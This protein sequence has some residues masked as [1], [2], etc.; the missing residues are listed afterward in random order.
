MLSSVLL[1]LNIGSG[2]MVLIVFAALM[3]FGG[4]KLPEIARGLGKGIRDFKDASEDVKREINNQ[5]NNYEEKK[6]EKAA[7]IAEEAGKEAEPATG[8]EHTYEPVAGTIPAYQG[9]TTVT[10]AEEHAH[11]T[12][13]ELAAAEDATYEHD[14]ELKHP[15]T[16][17]A[18]TTIDLAKKEDEPVKKTIEEEYK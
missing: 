2:E 11:V 15:A 13:N 7:E 8:S 6:T 1:F 14:A 5:I 10:D 12:D 3:L 4:K 18:K 16:N 9:Y 17:S